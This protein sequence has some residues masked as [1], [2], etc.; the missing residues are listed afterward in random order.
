MYTWHRII[1]ELA[2]DKKKERIVINVNHYQAVWK[3]MN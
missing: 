3:P 2:K 1:C